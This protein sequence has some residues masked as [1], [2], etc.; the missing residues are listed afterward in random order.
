MII[1][2]NNHPSV[3]LNNVV[4]FTAI[5]N[6]LRGFGEGKHILIA[7]KNFFDIIISSNRF[8]DTA[9]RFAFEAK[10][11]Q[12]EYNS[13]QSFVS[14]SLICDFGI[15]LDTFAWESSNSNDKLRVSPHFFNDSQSVQKTTIVCENSTDADFYRIVALYYS[16][17]ISPQFRCN[18]LFDAVNGGGGTTKSIFDRKIAEKTITLCILDNDKK[19]PKSSRGSTCKAFG[20]KSY[21]G[22]GKIKIIDAHEVESLIPLETIEEVIKKHGISKNKEDSLQFLKKITS[23]DE[24]TKFHFDHKNGINLSLAFTLDNK[25]GSYWIPAIKTISFP[26]PS[27]CLDSNDCKCQPPCFKMEGYG[28]NLLPQT[29]EHINYGNIHSYKPSLP[30]KLAE[31]WSDIGKEF[32]S[33]C[34][35][36]AK[37]ARM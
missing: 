11:A 30:E 19:H 4:H 33:W 12:M 15:H 26:Q 34:C 14:F 9:E 20:D 25:Y 18:L 37:K 10:R 23:F 5:E 1:S 22:T 3:D 13:L 6:L 21:Q 32:F 29:I 7:H 31:K 16:K 27:K 35:A 2:I 8:G 36:P 17:S 28:D 24:T